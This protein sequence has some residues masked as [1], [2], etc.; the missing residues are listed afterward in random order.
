MSHANPLSPAF[1]VLSFALF[2]FS[3]SF[4]FQAF[5]KKKTRLALS[6]KVITSSKA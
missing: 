4:E 1:Y 2:F 6:D 3:L 5:I